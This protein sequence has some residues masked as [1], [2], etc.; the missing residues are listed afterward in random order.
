M[1]LRIESHAT[2]IYLCL[3]TTNVQS[4]SLHVKRASITL[5]PMLQYSPFVGSL[6]L[7]DY[8]S[9]LVLL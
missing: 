5:L 6:M 4:P 9:W 1:W 3:E 2:T 7:P 8:A